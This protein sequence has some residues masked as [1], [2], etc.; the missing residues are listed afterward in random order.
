MIRHHVIRAFTL[1]AV[2]LAPAAC[3]NSG[4]PESLEPTKEATRRRHPDISH[5]SPAQVTRW[6]QDDA[7]DERLIVLDV[8]E[9]QE[10]EVSHLTGAV[11]IPPDAEASDLVAG[12]LRGVAKDRKIV[13]YCSVG[14]RSAAATERLVKAGFVNAHNMNG[15]IFEW[16]NEGNPVY[17]GDAK[18][19]QIH[20][21]NTRWG[22]FL[23][24]ELHGDQ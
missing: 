24:A 6:L 14:V 13:L 12:V 22:R 9:P 4:E 15:S 21:Y 1:I 3:S 8:R 19:R 11:Q 17:R 5:V 18:V 23:K 10:Y 16:A 7:S 2:S 20:P